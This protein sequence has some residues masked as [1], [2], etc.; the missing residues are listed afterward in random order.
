MP[1]NSPFLENALSHVYIKVPIAHK[2][3]LFQLQ[4]IYNFPFIEIVAESLQITVAK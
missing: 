2:F 3:K 1:G 4:D